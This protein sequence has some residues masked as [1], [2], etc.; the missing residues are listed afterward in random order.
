MIR[1][2]VYIIR[3]RFIFFSFLNLKLKTAKSYNGN[4]RDVNH[5]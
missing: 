5:I 1:N 4:I 3:V 2:V